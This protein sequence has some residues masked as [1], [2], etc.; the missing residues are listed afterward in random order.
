MPL[1]E[2]VDLVT[3]VQ[4]VPTLVSGVPSRFVS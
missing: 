2:T 4:V 1:D 3:T